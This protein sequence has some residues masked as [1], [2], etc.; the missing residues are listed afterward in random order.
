MR[1]SVH[2]YRLTVGNN[3]GYG[4]DMSATLNRISRRRQLYCSDRG[5]R[6]LDTLSKISPTLYVSLKNRQLLTVNGYL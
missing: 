4:E 5:A 2:G 6:E 1:I 3:C